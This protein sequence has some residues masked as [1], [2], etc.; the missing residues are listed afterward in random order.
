MRIEE[1]VREVVADSL[2]DDPKWHELVA[3]YR[4]DDLAKHVTMMGGTAIR[5]AMRE[6]ISTKAPDE[7]VVVLESAVALGGDV[8]GK[9]T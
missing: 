5:M 4:A 7:Q 9:L 2:A 3:Q 1:L 8:A 6:K